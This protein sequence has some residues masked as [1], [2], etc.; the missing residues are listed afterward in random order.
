MKRHTRN[1]KVAIHIITDDTMVK[2]EGPLVGTHLGRVS[3]TQ[4]GQ[5]NYFLLPAEQQKSPCRAHGKG[6]VGSLH[7]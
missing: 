3:E 1:V 7:I 5:L 2:N 6:L 4:Y